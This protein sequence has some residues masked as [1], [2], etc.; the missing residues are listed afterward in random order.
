MNRSTLGLLMAVVLLSAACND[1]NLRRTLARARADSTADSSS[2]P[3][4]S[5]G[6]DGGQ[7]D[8]EIAAAAFSETR[9]TL[10]RLVTAEETFFAEN[11]TYTDELSHSGIEAGLKHDDTVP[12]DLERR[13]GGQGY[14]YQSSRAGLR[15]LRRS[16]AEAA[17]NGQVRPTRPRGGSGL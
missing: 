9:G 1:V 11:G 15:D 17:H 3:T 6:R 16:R 14:P 10:R 12:A 13:L 2:G 7:I 4:Q 8:P 5:R